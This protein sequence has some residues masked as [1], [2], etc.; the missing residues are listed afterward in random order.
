MGYQ[1]P[2]EDQN[3]TKQ[4]IWDLVKLQTNSFKDLHGKDNIFM[5]MIYP[6]KRVYLHIVV[7]LTYPM[8]LSVST[9]QTCDE[10]FTFSHF[11][12]DLQLY[13]SG[14][15]LFRMQ[16]LRWICPSN[17]FP[18]GTSPHLFS[19]SMSILF[20]NI[21]FLLFEKVLNEL[22]NEAV[23]GLKPQPNILWA[24]LPKLVLDQWGMSCQKP[25]FNPWHLLQI[26]QY[27]YYDQHGIL[28]TSPQVD[29]H[30]NLSTWG[31]V[32]LGDKLDEHIQLYV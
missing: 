19:W 11:Q 30:Q 3:K 22:K 20:L 7:D 6:V 21:F 14:Y 23:I 15:G 31:E 8:Q 13:M 26:D 16:W 18:Q 29:K 2:A 10:P 17:L 27:Y 12:R 28:P 1:I 25:D 4:N 9:K 5:N 32:T 24:K